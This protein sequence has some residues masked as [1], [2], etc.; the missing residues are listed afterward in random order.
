[1]ASDQQ[2][3]LVDQRQP[4]G[5]EQPAVAKMPVTAP[6]RYS[7][8]VILKTILN[9]NDNGLGLAGERL[10]IGGWVKS[11]KELTKEEPVKTSDA[12]V[13]AGTPTEF[14]CAEVIQSRIPFLRTIIKVFGGQGNNVHDKLHPFMAKLPQPKIV[15][16]QISDG[17]C[18]QT[19]QVHSRCFAIY[20]L[21][22][23]NCL[24]LNLLFVLFFLKF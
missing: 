11:S 18:V 7:S 1:M 16:L 8:R 17:S 6:S 23:T 24:S 12:L 9:R 5:Q 3:H 19:L 2:E 4:E 21:Q 15:Y 14:T 20:L 22:Y 13:N 10:V